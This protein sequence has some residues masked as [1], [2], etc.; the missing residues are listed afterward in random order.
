M[1]SHFSLDTER[2]HTVR[3]QFPVRVDISVESGTEQKYAGVRVNN[4]SAGGMLL[5][6]PTAPDLRAICA[7]RAGAGLRCGGEVVRLK[8]RKCGIEVGFRFLEVSA[9]TLDSIQSRRGPL[10]F[11]TLE[12]ELAGCSTLVK[13]CRF[14]R[15]HEYV[16]RNYS[17]RISLS[18]VARATH[19]EPEW[20]SSVFH[21]CLGVQFRAWVRLIRISEAMLIFSGADRQVAEIAEQVGF[22]S[23]K[24]FERAFRY[25]TGLNPSQFKK[26]CLP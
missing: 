20:L 16:T 8:S 24:T 22:E 15:I 19:I 13:D 25:W 14:R 9:K 18:S 12:S 5:T 26:L 3:Y 2:R 7:I 21:E 11:W 23:L 10:Q 1:G 6:L 17:R 4:I